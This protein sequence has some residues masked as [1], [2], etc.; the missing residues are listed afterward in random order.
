M[1]NEPKVTVTVQLTNCITF[2][3]VQI[4]ALISLSINKT[5]IRLSIEHFS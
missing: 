1:T 2:F 3:N 4:S 5:C